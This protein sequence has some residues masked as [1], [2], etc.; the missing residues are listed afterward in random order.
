MRTDESKAREQEDLP[1]PSASRR[2][3]A[4]TLAGAAAAPFLAGAFPLPTRE[5]GQSP[6]PPPPTP[7][8]SPFV[9]AMTEAMRLRFG[10]RLPPDQLAGAG[11]ALARIS[12]NAERMRQVRLT[13][14][15]EPD[16]V[17][18]AAVRA[19]SGAD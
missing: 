6:P 1:A 14:A 3:F 5:A 15:D 4:K 10:S 17:F 18:F 9:E 8:P 12:R 11:E 13:N 19:G 2:S 16:V 7:S